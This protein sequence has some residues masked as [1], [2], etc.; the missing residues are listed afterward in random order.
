MTK[1]AVTHGFIR[2]SSREIKEIKTVAT[3]YEHEKSGAQ[4]LHLACDDSNKVFCMAFKTIPEDDTGCP[5]IL[6]HSVLNG[7]KNFPGKSTFMELIKGSMHTFI[8]AMTASDMT[9]YPV[10]STNDKDFLNLTRV[11]LDAVLFPKIYEQ[12]N[13]LHQE[14][15]HYELNSPDDELKVRGVV[16]NEMK[17]AFSSVD[18]IIFRH[19]QQAQFPDTPYGFESG[20]DPDAILQL[21]YDKFIAF[22][23]KYYHPSNSKIVIYGDMDL[24]AT[25]ELID[26]DYLSHFERSADLAEMP[27]QKPFARQIKLEKE[28]PADEHKDI[29]DQYHLS[30]NYSYGQITDPY[31][32]DALSVLAELLMTSP[33][34]PLKQKIMASGLAA[35]SFCY[36]SVDILQPTLI[37][38][39][40]QLR[41]ENIEALVKLVND[42]LKRIVR[43]GFDKSLIEAVLNKREFF[44]REAQMQ[45]FPKGLYYIWTSLPLWMHGGDPCDALSFEPQLKE[46]RKGLTEPYFEN[47]IDTV[48]LNNHHSSQITFVPVPGLLGVKEQELRDKLAARKAKMSKDEIDGLVEFNR[49]FA[50]WQQEEVSAEDLAR[51]PK[52][53]L[54]DINPKSDSYPLE[55]DRKEDYC[56][57]RHPVNTN[58]IVYLKAYIDLRQAAEEDFSW[59]SLYSYLVGKM[60][61]AGHSYAELSNL[62]DTHTGGISLALRFLSNYQDPDEILTRFVISGK[63][64]AGKV[65]TLAELAAEFACRPVF[66]DGERLCSVIREL[67]TRMEMQLGRGGVSVAI[68]RMFAPFSQ[69]HRFQDQANGMAYYHF[70]CD[71]EKRLQNDLPGVRKNLE[72]VRDNYFNRQ[73]LVLSLTAAEEEI[74]SASACLSPLTGAFSTQACEAAIIPFQGQNIREG[75]LAPVQIQFCVQGGNFF[76]KGYSYSGKMAVMN[77]ILSNE[78][79]HRE[80]REKGGAYGAWSNIGMTGYL[81]FVS[82][83]DPN[84]KQTLDVYAG[85]PEYLRNFTCSKRELDK[86]IIGVISSL[87]YPL[88]P[89]EIGAQSD[90]DHLTGFTQQDRQQVRDEALS[91]QVEDIRSYA[92]MVED[93]IAAKHYCVFGNEDKVKENGKLF[94]ILTPLY[95]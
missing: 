3:V 5:H 85:V 95:K 10:G 47:L 49:Q 84:L 21:D 23:Q 69:L 68:T 80:I 70:L 55:L 6:E 82:Y 28:Y 12:P 75:I 51:I 93:V 26:K 13:I 67:K 92:G 16:Y 38:I 14:G 40:K 50:A 54:A 58:G 33:A 2:K 83:M 61:S 91:T 86:Y 36:P 27:P 34:S 66:E 53:D 64:V 22:H 24:D 48:L 72:R 57:L 74:A 11:Y 1:Q 32:A 17:G 79:L 35:D 42:E 37:F 81:S 62:I 78:F 59:L 19:C 25:L 39:F 77:N 87:D 4:L 88:T 45:R 65:E 31:T 76:R 7:S 73:N 20:G 9:M 46:L 44:L 63:A 90:T 43:E 60:D 56:L 52:L 15:W 41:K 30:L 29:A 94:D 71:L 8:N 89:E 18:T